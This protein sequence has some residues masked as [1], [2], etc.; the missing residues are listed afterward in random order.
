MLVWHDPAVASNSP[1][2]EQ[3][4]PVSYDALR[5]FVVAV[6]VHAGDD[7]AALMGITA[8]GAITSL[9][10]AA[11]AAVTF[12]PSSSDAI[13]DKSATDAGSAGD[14]AAHARRNARLALAFLAAAAPL[15]ATKHDPASFGELMTIPAGL[16]WSVLGWLAARDWQKSGGMGSFLMSPVVAGAL[17]ANLGV[18][19]HAKLAGVDYMTAMHNYFGQVSMDE[20]TCHA[21]CRPIVCP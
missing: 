12:M 18:F 11:R 6:L 10:F 19:W 5:L 21:G 1:A 9:I 7:V 4:V 17:T 3:K 8:A 20:I 2:A 15:A 16:A 14:D 13:N